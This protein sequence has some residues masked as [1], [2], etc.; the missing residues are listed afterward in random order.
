MA[1][2]D[3][4]RIVRF[5]FLSMMFKMGMRMRPPLEADSLS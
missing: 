3:L 5:A 4:P 2:F 1:V